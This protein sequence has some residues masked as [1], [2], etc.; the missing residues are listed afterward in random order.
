MRLR[1]DSMDN[2]WELDSILNKKHGDVIANNIP[3]ALGG[4][5]FLHIGKLAVGSFGNCFTAFNEDINKYIHISSICESK[6]R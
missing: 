6:S 1:L 3:I 5:V 2:I 4:I